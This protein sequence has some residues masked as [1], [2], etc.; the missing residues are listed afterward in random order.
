MHKI[1]DAQTQERR[2]TGATRGEWW[3]F[4]L[5]EIRDGCIR[6]AKGAELQ[7]YDPWRHFANTRKLAIGQAPAVAQLDYQSLLSLVHQLEYLPGHVR[8]PDCLTQKSQALILEWCQQHGLLGI[9]LSRW[10]AISLAPQPDQADLWTHRR[11]SRGFGQVIQTQHSSGDVSDRTASVLI[12][13]LNDLTITEEPP[14]QTWSRFFPSVEFSKRDSFPYP[15]PYTVEF[16][17]LYGEPSWISVKQPNFWWRRS[18]IWDASPWRSKAIRKL[19][20]SKH[21]MRSICF[22]GL[23]TPFWNLNKTDR[24]GLVASP[25]LCSPASR[26]CS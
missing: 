8:Y 23:S 13:G 6:P 25:L 26:T 17:Q 19:R 2:R 11:Y 9:L 5:Y 16:C 21:S 14:S 22:A 18:R 1:D 4:S 20:A 12:R 3:R 7:W 15:Q 10:E 24:C